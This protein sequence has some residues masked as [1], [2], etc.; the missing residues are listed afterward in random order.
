V[1]TVAGSEAVGAF[2]GHLRSTHFLA[3]TITALT[4]QKRLWADGVRPSPLHGGAPS[5]DDE[6][7]SAAGRPYVVG[8]L[9]LGGADHAMPTKDRIPV[10]PLHNP[11]RDH[12]FWLAGEQQGRAGTRQGDHHSPPSAPMVASAACV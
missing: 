9:A 4:E 1:P 10:K 7:A 6:T 8:G 12:C 11:S 5:T 2:G 3:V